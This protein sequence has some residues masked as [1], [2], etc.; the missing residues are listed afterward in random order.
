MPALVPFR[1]IPELFRNLTA[2]FAGQGRAMLTYKDKK[3]KQWVNLTYE[4][5]QAQVEAFAGFLHARG[6]RPGDRVAILAENRPEWVVADLATQLLG[7]VNVSLYTTLPPSQVGYIVKDSGSKIFVVSTP[8]QLR[9]AEEVFDR[10]P[11]LETLVAMEP[12]KDR[13]PQTVTWD[14]ALREGANHYKAHAAE[15]A[16]LGEAVRPDDLCALI[17]TSGTTGVPKGVMLTH[18]NFCENVNSSLGR[19]DFGPTDVHLSFLPLCHSFE[20]TAGYTAV[21]SCGARIAYAESVDAVSKNLPEVQPTVL[22]SV[23]R[24]FER[25][26]AGVMKGLEGQSPAKVKIF[27]W[28]V[29]TGRKVAAVRAAGK[30][31]GPILAAQQK[32]AHALV[33]SKL[34]EKLGGRVRFAVSGGAALP[35]HIGEFFEAAGL[36]IIE[37]YGLTETS[38]VLSFNPMHAPRF[39]TVGHVIP[40]V[41]IGIYREG[42][43]IAQQK[44]DD[45]P[46]NLDTD[47]GEIVAKGPN[48]MRG[49]WGN[50]AA[51]REAIDDQGWYHTGDVGRFE[52]GYL[53]ITDRIKHMLVS[54]GGKNIYPGPIEDQLKGMSNLIEQLIVLGEGRE[55]LTVLVVPNADAAKA[56]TGET[57]DEAARAHPKVEEELRKVIK[58]YS[59]TAA[60][61]EK[62]RD[63]R[64]LAE[65]FTIE[66][67]MM[68][69][70]MSLKRKAIEQHH[71]ALIEGMYAG[72][73]EEE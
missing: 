60:S 1:T 15:I 13:T 61:H 22:I 18:E 28:A 17:Y 45:Y 55:F 19:L 51:T 40:G 25:V 59:R 70:K 9:K 58:A 36:R 12:R 2:H 14:D 43:I 54:K 71:A 6:I 20:R 42:Q 63:L 4:D 73:G 21:M 37:G 5:V 38:P 16:A 46:S 47:E 68:T 56:L 50:D 7:A 8:M 31:P 67:E 24:V 34:H 11:E 65:P 64:V 69:P 30:T 53:R 32:V 66:N 48:I 27:D 62:V 57:T 33:F 49:Y 29:R 72:K 41:T 10:C 3:S 39:G 35:R 44:G 52:D 23:P 26:Y